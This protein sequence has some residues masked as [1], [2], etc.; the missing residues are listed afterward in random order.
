MKNGTQHPAVEAND[1]DASEGTI[2]IG[3]DGLPTHEFLLKEGGYVGMNLGGIGGKDSN[4]ADAANVD[5]K[6]VTSV[7]SY[8]DALMGH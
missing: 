6:R 8:A 1:D 5:A 3:P 4:D 2:N 7:K